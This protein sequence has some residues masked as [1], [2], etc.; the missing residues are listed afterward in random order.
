ML[1]HFPQAEHAR[2]IDPIFELPAGDRFHLWSAAAD[3]AKIGVSS[4][5]SA[6]QRRA[7]IVGTR[8]AATK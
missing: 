1:D 8:F 5:Q 6:H 4:L 7:V 3:E 2:V